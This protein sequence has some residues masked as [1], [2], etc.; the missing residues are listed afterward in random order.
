MRSDA[1]VGAIVWSLRKRAASL[2]LDLPCSIWTANPLLLH[3]A[4][5]SEGGSIIFQRTSRATGGMQAQLCIWQAF[6]FTVCVWFYSSCS[7]FTVF[8]VM[9]CFCKCKL[10][11]NVARTNDCYCNNGNIWY[12]NIRTVYRGCG[13]LWHRRHVA[14]TMRLVALAYWL[15]NGTA[16]ANACAYVWISICNQKRACFFSCVAAATIFIVYFPLLLLL[17]FLF[18][19]SLYFPL[20]TV[21]M[22]SFL[23]LWHHNYLFLLLLL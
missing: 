13:W 12:I 4:L 22:D 19:K 3:C 6:I 11:G 1:R 20:L 18:C 16:I 9:F 14:L 8:V 10:N 7:Y 2:V 21:C 5:C 17:L 23:S 15:R